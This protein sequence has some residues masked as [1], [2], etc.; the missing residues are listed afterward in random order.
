MVTHRP[1]SSS[2][3][4]SYLESHK[5]IPK[6]ELLRGLWFG[7]QGVQATFRLHEGL[8]RSGRLEYGTSLQGSRSSLRVGFRV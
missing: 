3:C 2:F 4:G 6:M 7:F 5:V 1:L 8:G